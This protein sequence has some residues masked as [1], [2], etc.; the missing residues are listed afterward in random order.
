MPG[1]ARSFPYIV[2][3]CAAIVMAFSLLNHPAWQKVAASVRDALERVEVTEAS[4]FVHFF[5]G[6]LSQ[7]RDILVEMGCGD[8]PAE[9]LV[10]LWGQAR[11]PSKR[12][13]Q[14]MASFT[15]LEAT[16]REVVRARESKRSRTASLQSTSY[17]TAVTPQVFHRP[18]I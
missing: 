2:S 12:H 1:E 14:Q 6:S 7:A 15:V 8:E 18:W 16:S 13:T 9:Q 17:S 11:A 4:E 3:P 5:D 10:V